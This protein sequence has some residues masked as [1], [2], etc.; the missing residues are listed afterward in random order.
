MKMP[1]LFMLLTGEGNE[2]ELDILIAGCES[3]SNLTHMNLG[4]WISSRYPYELVAERAA[5][6]YCT[7]TIGA[8]ACP[9]EDFATIIQLLQSI[10]MKNTEGFLFINLKF[11]MS[12]EELK[13]NPFTA[14]S[15]EV[16][17]SAGETEFE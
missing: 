16:F 3:H 10:P 4:G 7:L 6:A 9:A 15:W 12:P 2:K 1:K 17:Q 8:Y 11:A 5:S 13:Q 14:M